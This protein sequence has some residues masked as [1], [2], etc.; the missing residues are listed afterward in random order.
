[1]KKLISLILVLCMACMLIPAVAEEDLTGEWY[2]TMAG[3]EMVLNLAE[4]GSATFSMPALGNTSSG[5]WTRDGDKITI[6]I[7]DSPAEA[8]YADGTITLGE[9]EASMVFTREK[10][11]GIKLAE[12]NPAAAA[13]DFEG[14]WSIAYVGYGEMV[15]DAS[16]S[17]EPLPGLVVEN[18]AMKFTGESSMSQVFGENPLQLAYADG[19]LSFSVAL[20]ETTYGIKLEMLADGMLAMTVN[21]GSINVFMYFVKAAA[22]E[23]AA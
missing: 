13:E 4:D 12:V 18:G 16:V 9:G 17:T 8:V 2:A 14:S 15:V 11:E 3:V 6:T 5:I 23:P 22:E 19:A 21:M 1:M 20:G 10:V 7:E